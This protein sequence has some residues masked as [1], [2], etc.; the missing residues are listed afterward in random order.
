MLWK[1]ETDPRILREEVT[2]SREEVVFIDEIQRIPS[3]LDEIQTLIDETEKIFILTGSSARKLKRKGINLLP[4]R[5]LSFKLL[6]LS[7]EEIRSY[8]PDFS[9][10]TLKKILRFGEL[11][12]IFTLVFNN[13]EKTATDL[14]FSYTETYLEKEIKA[15]ALV[16]RA[17]NFSNF[18]KIA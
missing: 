5:A 2:A 17:G 8:L 12:R 10:A 13:K 11:P 4:G 6:P 3:L 7:I 1:F 9:K 18:L 15:E 16:R 14:L